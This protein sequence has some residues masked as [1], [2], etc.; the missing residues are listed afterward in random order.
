MLDNVWRTTAW[1]DSFA[2]NLGK[3]ALNVATLS[4]KQHKKSN[5]LITSSYWGERRM[6][7]AISRGTVVQ[8][9]L[10]IIPSMCSKYLGWVI[11]KHL[12]L[13]DKTI[14]GFAV[15]A[16]DLITRHSATGNEWARRHVDAAHMVIYYECISASQRLLSSAQPKDRSKPTCRVRL[17]KRSG[18]TV[19]SRRRWRR[20]LAL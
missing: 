17:R 13:V 14:R 10:T 12:C 19:R 15:A 11:P 6:R 1:W 3:C 7:R 5:N 8:H 4:W 9:K 18:C 16:M 2:N 20:R